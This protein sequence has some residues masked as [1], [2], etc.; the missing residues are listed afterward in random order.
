LKQFSQ[1]VEEVD[2]GDSSDG[3]HLDVSG[4][5]LS[6]YTMLNIAVPLNTWV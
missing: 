5:W 3:L 2:G 6:T 1:C 4:K